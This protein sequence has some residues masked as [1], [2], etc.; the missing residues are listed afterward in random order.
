MERTFGLFG[1]SIMDA[2][3]GS[4][5]LT[6]TFIS[7]LQRFYPQDKLHIISFMSNNQIARRATI[8]R[9]TSKI[10]WKINYKNLYKFMVP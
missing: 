7:M 8:K 4:E 5:A 2:N 3:K 6:Y 1:L 10:K 9:K